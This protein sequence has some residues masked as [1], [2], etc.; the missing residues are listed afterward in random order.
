MLIPM[1]QLVAEAM[2]AGHAVP[3]F[4][5]YDFTTALAVVAEAEAQNRAAILNVAPKTASSASGLRLICALRT[6]G[7]QA[8]VPVAVQLD[9]ASDAQLIARAVQ[10]GATAVL[11]DGSAG[12]LE[13]N[14]SFVQQ[15][16]SLIGPDIV[17]EAE[18]GALPGNEDKAFEQSASQLTDPE[19]V[20]QFL[21]ASGADLLA[22]AIGNVHGR[23]KGEPK[24][25]WDVLK[26]IHAESTVPLVLHG[27]SG[28]AAPDLSRSIAYGVGKVNLNTELRSSTLTMLAEQLESRRADGQNILGLLGDWERAVTEVAASTFAALVSS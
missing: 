28:I 8:T 6:L 16:R 1:N 14:I 3:A 22:V 9:H 26:A 13:E 5:C 15:V 11:A 2:A 20:A 24:I 27:A 18:L 4:T 12:S 23:Y 10:A 7:G 21:D 19:Q 17:L 25:H